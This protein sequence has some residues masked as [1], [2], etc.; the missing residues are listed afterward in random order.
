[1]WL[2]LSAFKYQLHIHFRLLRNWHSLIEAC[3]ER[4]KVPGYKLNYILLVAIELTQ[5]NSIPLSNVNS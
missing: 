4:M 2:W 1:M 3:S 5:N